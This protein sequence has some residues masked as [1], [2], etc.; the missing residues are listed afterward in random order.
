MA[1]EGFGIYKI[2]DHS[3]G[4]EFVAKSEVVLTRAEVETLSK[5]LRDYYIILKCL[6]QL[7]IR[8][9]KARPIDSVAEFKR[10]YP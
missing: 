8:E 5:W 6:E 7:G 3:L 10:I 1:N 4:M 9:V 2:Y